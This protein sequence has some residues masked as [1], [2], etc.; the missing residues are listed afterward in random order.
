MTFI[1]ICTPYSSLRLLSPR[2]QRAC[3]PEGR[4]DIRSW[5]EYR[6]W[7]MEGQEKSAERGRGR[8]HW[9]NMQQ[10]RAGGTLSFNKISI[11]LFFKMGWSL[12]RSYGAVLKH[13]RHW[14]NLQSRPH[15][16]IT[17]KHSTTTQGK[18]MKKSPCQK[19]HVSMSLTRPT[20]TEHWWALMT[21]MT[22]RLPITSRLSTKRC[23][24][25]QDLQ[26]HPKTPI[27]A[28][29][30]SSFRLQHLQSHQ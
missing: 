21:S 26:C 25:L 9:L 30:S 27:E 16:P 1:A 19:T 10:L 28:W 5:K 15:A 14:A 23:F 6:G 7:L 29:R 18:R 20:R 8:T 4:A 17:S 13:D 2:R 22:L 3:N 24:N 12:D 11:T